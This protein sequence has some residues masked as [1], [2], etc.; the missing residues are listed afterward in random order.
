MALTSLAIADLLS[1][2]TLK[3]FITSIKKILHEENLLNDEDKATI[4]ES[5]QLLGSPWSLMFSLS[6]LALIFFSIRGGLVLFSDIKTTTKIGDF[7]LHLSPI[8]NML[9]IMVVLK[10]K[11]DGKNAHPFTSTGP[12]FLLLPL[13]LF[14]F[15]SR[16]LSKYVLSLLGVFVFIFAWTIF[17]L[18]VTNY[19]MFGI[20]KETWLKLRGKYNG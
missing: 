6:Y 15:E 19:E 5:K 11:L 8:P 4:N 16:A 20:P 17:S 2:G 13:S 14:L 3:L 7:F 12:I 9:T 18:V 10:K 1:E